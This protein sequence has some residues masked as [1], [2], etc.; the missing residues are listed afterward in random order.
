MNH[1]TLTLPFNVGG[2]EAERLL[3]TAWLFKIASHR[4]LNLAKQS[5][6]LPATDIGW[7]NTFRKVV[8]EVI[9]NRRYTDGVI[10]LVRGIY[11]S[12]RQLG[13][14]FRE[15]ELGDWLM[16]HQVEGCMLFLV[17]R[18]FKVSV[19][20]L[21]LFFATTDTY[22]PFLLKS[23][24]GDLRWGHARLWRRETVMNRPTET[25]DDL[26]RETVSSPLR[27]L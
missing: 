22:K 8:Y 6:L 15:V 1:I 19:G 18:S 25:Y 5:P 27:L 23:Y 14:D 17:F 9:P 10:V 20:C 16:F 12:C 24:L 7:K 13:V 3:S 26:G 21:M 4:M 11:E 2:R